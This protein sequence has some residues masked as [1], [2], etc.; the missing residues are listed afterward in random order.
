M[1]DKAYTF[2]DLEVISAAMLSEKSWPNMAPT[3]RD[4]RQIAKI[5]G[6]N[7]ATEVL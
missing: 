6:F 7:N 1:A 2:H 4:L 3:D 5:A